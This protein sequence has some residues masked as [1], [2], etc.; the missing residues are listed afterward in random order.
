MFDDTDQQLR[1]QLHSSHAATQL[2]LG[3]LIHQSDNY[4]GS[5]RGT[6]FEL[7]TD[8]YG[9]VRTGSGLLLTT[10]H[11]ASPHGLPEPAGEFS[12]GQALLKQAGLMGQSLSQAAHT[13][14]S[15]SL[16]A[17]EG[18]QQA[19]Q[20]QIDDKAA[21]LKALY[22]AASG[23][24][25]G[26]EL[27]AARQDAAN[28]HIHTPPDKLPHSSDPILGMAAKGGLGM[29]AGGSIQFSN[30]E[31]LSWMSGEDT[32]F[33]VGNQLHVHSGQ[34]IGVTAGVSQPG[35][36]DSGIQ[37]IAAQG[38]IE[39]QAQS[40][41][42]ALRAQG[43]MKL[44]SAQAHIDMAAAKSIKI[45]VAGGAYIKIE[46][47]NID[48]HCPGTIRIQAGQKSLS[49]PDNK[50]FPLVAFPKGRLAFDEPFQLLD[51]A[52]DPIAHMRYEMTKPNG[53]KIQGV[54]DAQ[55]NVPLQQGFSSEQLK[56]KLLGRVKKGEM[57]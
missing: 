48:F 6:G 18:A 13:H 47:G 40:N 4:R 52:G 21:P 44:T 50:S 22:T 38:P 24:V 56:L 3:H 43:S 10:Y 33:A 27:E 49:G 42:L 55:G 2:N 41:T 9:A 37:L 23:M 19:G 34:A 35:A 1:V 12:A 20:S 8:A 17:H 15:V 51:P 46:G 28:K 7:R 31:T 57:P 39:M 54:T 36:G 16:A 11:Q 5:F 30:Q 32:N 53:V 14:Q 29:T 25:S 45:G 26:S